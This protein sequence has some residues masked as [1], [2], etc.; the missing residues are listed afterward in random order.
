[1]KTHRLFQWL[2][3]LLQPAPIFGAAIIAIFWIGL[4]Y[5]LSVE[6]AKAIDTAIE[7]GGGAARLFE[8]ATIRLLKGVDQTILL[9]RLAY[10]E[11]P[12]N[13]DLNRLVDRTSLVGDLTIQAS[14]I[15][16]DGYLKSS[17][18]E[19]TGAPLYLGDREHFQVQVD[20][21]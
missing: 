15:G 8:E 3:C 17:S 11:N 14:L 19:Y 5:Q 20:A 2:R 21:K 1:M 9:I 16:P 6:R 13:F 7:R 18:A 4:A 10:E 12:E